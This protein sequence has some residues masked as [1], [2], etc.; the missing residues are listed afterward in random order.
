[1]TREEK[2]NIVDQE[3]NK[4]DKIRQKLMGLIQTNKGE[5]SYYYLLKT[6]PLLNQADIELSMYYKLLSNEIHQD[7]NSISNNE[8]R[9]D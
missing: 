9:D 6:L 2:L 3:I 7:G 8:I 5:L 1:M 4:L